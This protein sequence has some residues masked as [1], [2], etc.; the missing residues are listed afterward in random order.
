MLLMLGSRSENLLIVPL[1]VCKKQYPEILESVV[2]AANNILIHIKDKTI[3]H[4][5]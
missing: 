5:Y 2:Q 1:Q 4:L 3:M